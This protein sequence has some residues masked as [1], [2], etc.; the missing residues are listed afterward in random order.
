MLFHCIPKLH[1]KDSS[2]DFTMRSVLVA[3]KAL[4]SAVNDKSIF[5]MSSVK[6][7]N[8]NEIR[9]TK[10]KDFTDEI[11]KEF[12]ERNLQLNADSFSYPELLNPIF[13]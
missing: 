10:N 8:D 13:G 2:F 12:L 9:Y 4:V 5:S 1:N 6:Q 7:N 3:Q 11:A